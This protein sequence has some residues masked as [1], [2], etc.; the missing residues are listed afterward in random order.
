[1]THIRRFAFAGALAALASPAAAVSLDDYSSLIVFGD[2][3]S[4]PGNLFAQV[5]V[6]GF[7]YF[8]GRFSSGPVW[9]EY[10]TDDFTVSGNF[11]FGGAQAAT[12]D[13][14]IPDFA[15]QIDLYQASP[16]GAVQGDNPLAAIWFG[17]NDLF[18]AIPSGSFTEIGA[19]AAA[20]V[21]SISSGIVDLATNSGIT[22]FV[23]FN[24]PDLGLTPLYS[25]VFP[26]ASDG[27]SDATDFFN[28]LLG[29]AVAGLD[30][31]PGLD[32]EI[33]DVNAL[34]DDLVANPDAFG[35]TNVT[36]PCNYISGDPFVAAAA[37]AV[38]AEVG[39]EVLCSGDEV[40]NRAFFDL[41]HPNGQVH[42]ELARRFGAEV[43]MTPIP[44]PAGLPLLA[45][46][47]GGL[48]LAGRRSARGRVA[49]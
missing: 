31:L 43:E 25:K 48:I 15:A 1:M 40:E 37:A 4:D 8:D 23:V 41:V 33:F 18:G 14:G 30:A 17:A 26:A 12:D 42:A 3:L 19:A 10:A 32:V 49:R 36:H 44:L 9:A 39:D 34:F 38:A 27:A 46:G 13:D 28:V 5:G 45:V 22:D 7:P 20:A 2:S 21:A 29:N 47:L 35:V 16:L 6:P 11:A 24:L